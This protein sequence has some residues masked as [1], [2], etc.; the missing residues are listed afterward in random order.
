MVWIEN[1]SSDGEKLEVVTLTFNGSGLGQDYSRQQPRQ[2]SPDRKRGFE[3]SPCELLQ[4]K[5]LK[6]ALRDLIDNEKG[7]C[8]RQVLLFRRRGRKTFPHDSKVAIPK[9]SKA[10]LGRVAE[11]GE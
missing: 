10:Q 8:H 6:A 11:R 5:R 9:G 2:D 4:I 1:M 3:A 7:D